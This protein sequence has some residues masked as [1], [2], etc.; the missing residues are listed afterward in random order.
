MECFVSVKQI[1]EKSM[2]RNLFIFLILAL[3]VLAK[4]LSAQE[5]IVTLTPGSGFPGSKGSIVRIEL[6]NDQVVSGFETHIHF[7]PNVL[8]VCDE[9]SFEC[10]HCGPCCVCQTSRTRWGLFAYSAPAGAG[11]LVVVRYTEMYV[12]DPGTGSIVDI[13]FDVADTAR[14]AEYDITLGS[15]WLWTP[16][17]T[18]IPYNPVNGVFS[19]VHKGDV[20]GDGNVNVLDLVITILIILDKYQGTPG[21]L[22]VA[23]CIDDSQVDVRDVLCIVE[24]I[25]GF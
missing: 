25:I 21:E 16:A 18:E 15:I 9:D 24:I 7:D 3:A 13:K 12:I 6:D 11:S 10:S 1:I 22:S 23:D 19:V 2:K 17:A 20:N 8:S 5:A 14:L 4:S